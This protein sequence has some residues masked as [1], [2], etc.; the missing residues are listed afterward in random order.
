VE[1]LHV[2]INGFKKGLI[3]GYGN[4]IFF[5]NC[6]VRWQKSTLAISERAVY[7]GSF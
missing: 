4:H 1:K 5:K 3:A 2:L 7:A 6:L